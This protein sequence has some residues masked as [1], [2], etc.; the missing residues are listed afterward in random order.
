MSEVAPSSSQG[1]HPLRGAGN[2]TGDAPAHDDQRDNRDEKHI[3]KRTQKGFF[4]D[5]LNV[6]RDVADVVNQCEGSSDGLVIVGRMK[7]QG[8]NVQSGIPRPLKDPGSLPLLQC[9]ADDLKCAT[10]Q[11]RQVV[12]SNN[13]VILR[14]VDGDTEK[15]FAVGELIHGSTQR[16][17]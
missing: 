14:V 16:T 4:P 15:V 1:S 5:P 9:L 6:S 2:W 13:E 17:H 8:I 7:R 10:V 3:D 11:L 12:S